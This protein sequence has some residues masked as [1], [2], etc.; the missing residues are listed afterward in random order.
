MKTKVM[1][2]VVLIGAIASNTGFAQETPDRQPATNSTPPRP[3]ED[4][5]RPTMTN[6]QVELT[7]TDSYGSA[8][9][10]KKTISMIIADGQMGRIR[11]A[12]AGSPAVLNVD[13]TPVLFSTERVRLQL[14]LE[15]SPPYSG[16]SGTRLAAI[17]EMVTVH[18]VPGKP[19]LVSQ[20]AD[21]SV[22]RKV[23]VEVTATI[24]K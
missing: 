14:V 9:P 18:L 10:Q 3:A 22:D 19:T 7:V 2:A 17:N 23:T 21:P 24:L 20:A 13:A 16:E 12:R 4:R 11:S 5:P 1:A 15:Y 6:V 8:G